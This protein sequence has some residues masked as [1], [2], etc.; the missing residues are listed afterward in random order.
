MVE[1]CSKDHRFKDKFIVTSALGL[2]FYVGAP[3]RNADGCQ[4]GQLCA[5]GSE[6]RT[7]NKAEAVILGTSHVLL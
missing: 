6:A 7:L 5:F 4:L 1:D 2:R 3:I